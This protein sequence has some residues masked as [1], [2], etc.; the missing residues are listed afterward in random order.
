MLYLAPDCMIRITIRSS[1]LH[2]RNEVV[3]VSLKTKHV[4]QISSVLPSANDL[5]TN[6]Q[7]SRGT[8][9]IIFMGLHNAITNPW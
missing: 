5:D 7:L 4:A 1:V 6:K 8:L 2:I 9:A 3:V